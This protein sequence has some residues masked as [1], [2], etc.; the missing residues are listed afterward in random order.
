MENL[1]R[2]LRYTSAGL[3]ELF[4]TRTG[5]QSRMNMTMK[6]RRG[7]YGLMFKAHGDKSTQSIWLVKHGG[8][9]VCRSGDPHD[10]TQRSVKRREANTHSRYPQ[11]G[12][13]NRLIGGDQS[14]FRR[15]IKPGERGKRRE[16]IVVD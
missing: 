16:A 9:R 15:T 13:L 10:D 1:L 14:N 4:E 2:D 8:W 11:G 7:D 3:R 5:K 12:R 6:H